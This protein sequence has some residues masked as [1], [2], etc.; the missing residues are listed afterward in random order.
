M[1]V[2]VSDGGGGGDGGGYFLVKEKAKRPIYT[3]ELCKKMN[4]PSPPP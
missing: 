4:P 3:R 2:A 1:A